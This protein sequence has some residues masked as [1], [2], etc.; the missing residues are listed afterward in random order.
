MLTYSQQPDCAATQAYVFA[1]CASALK[2]VQSDPWGTS[3]TFLGYCTMVWLLKRG[4][5][6]AADRFKAILFSAIVIKSVNMI[7]E[8]KAAKQASGRKDK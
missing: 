2:A 8:G 3:A 4:T 1:T 7:L 6:V 5:Y